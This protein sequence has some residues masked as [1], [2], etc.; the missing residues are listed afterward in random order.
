MLSALEPEI[1][2]YVLTH[3]L[4]HLLHMNHSAAFWAQVEAWLPDA[5]ELRNRMRRAER[6]LAAQ[7]WE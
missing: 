5:V 6:R 7:K 4:T 3:E 1:G 2:A